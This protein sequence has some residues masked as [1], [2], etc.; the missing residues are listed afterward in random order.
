MSAGS[1]PV[2]IP[3]PLGLSVS[4]ALPLTTRHLGL[5]LEQLLLLPVERVLL[6]FLHDGIGAK[7]GPGGRRPHAIIPILLI[8]SRTGCA[9]ALALASHR[10]HQEARSHR[11]HPPHIPRT[12]AAHPSAR[13]RC[14]QSEPHSKR[15]AATDGAAGGQTVCKD[16]RVDVPRAGRGDLAGRTAHHRPSHHHTLGHGPSLGRRI[17]PSSGNPGGRGG[18]GG[19]G[20]GGDHYA[21][22]NVTSTS[23]PH[24][25]DRASASA[26]C[27][28]AI[29][30]CAPHGR[31]AAQQPQQALLPPLH[32][33]P[34]SCS[35][36]RLEAPK[37]T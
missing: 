1:L 19:H 36:P 6:G 17:H 2:S 24:G 32:S 3:E 37:A 33:G 9:G 16:V 11:L 23:G 30:F 28:V 5:S 26:A 21:R 15:K 10:I 4:P 13:C 27:L 12:S 29:C 31:V 14:T 18:R 34:A 35:P 20:R 22:A 25:S 8:S 7:A